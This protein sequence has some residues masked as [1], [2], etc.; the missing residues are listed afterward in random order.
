[1]PSLD[2]L[3][4]AFEDALAIG[5]RHLLVMLLQK[6]LRRRQVV[7]VQV[8]QRRQ[9]RRHRRCAR[10]RRRGLAQEP[11][12]V[13]RLRLLGAGMRLRVSHGS[14]HFDLSGLKVWIVDPQ[15][16]SAVLFLHWTGPSA[17]SAGPA[18]GAS[19]ETAAC[20][21]RG[22]E[23]TAAAAA[24]LALLPVPVDATV[25]AVLP[26]TVNRPVTL[27]AKQLGLIPWNRIPEIVHERIP[28]RGMMT[29]ETA[30]VDPVLEHNLRVL[31]QPGRRLGRR[32]QDHVAV[33]APILEPGGH[34][35]RL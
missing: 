19:L 2:L 12:P 11:A 4:D 28:L 33:A 8:T 15:R 18:P 17:V 21:G 27:G 13:H 35:T 23:C 3:P 26:V 16:T 9:R 7:R 29:I 6:L 1:M 20:A 5:R 32:R 10:Q 25:G 22:N 34:V 24:A 30:G 31:G 14:M